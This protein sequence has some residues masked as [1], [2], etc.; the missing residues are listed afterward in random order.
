MRRQT[1]KK[2]SFYVPLISQDFADYELTGVDSHSSCKKIYLLTSKGLR[3]ICNIFF[4]A[5]LIGLC[6]ALHVRTI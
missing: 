6:Y 2:F 4:Q 1:H 5:F 3:N